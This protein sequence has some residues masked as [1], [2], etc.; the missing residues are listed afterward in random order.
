MVPTTA[1]LTDDGASY[2]VNRQTDPETQEMERVD[3][4]VLA[5]NDDFAVVGKPDDAASDQNPDMPA[6][7]LADGDT[8]S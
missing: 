2:Y 8:S 7:P 4:E 1:L 6:S 5:K 3:V